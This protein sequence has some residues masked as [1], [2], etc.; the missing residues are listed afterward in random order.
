MPHRIATFDHRGCSLCFGGRHF[1]GFRRAC[2]S[3]RGVDEES[4]RRAKGDNGVGP[5]VEDSAP[6]AR[7]VFARL[8]SPGASPSRG[9]NWR[10]GSG[11]AVLSS[12]GRAGRGTGLDHG[13]G[14]FSPVGTRDH[15]A[16][17]WRY[18]LWLSAF[19]YG[20]KAFGRAIGRG[21]RQR[22]KWDFF[23]GKSSHFV[24][25]CPIHFYLFGACEA[26]LESLS[27]ER[28]RRGR[29]MRHFGFWIG[30]ANAGVRGHS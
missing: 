28:T 3:W 13:E 20:F 18:P 30:G 26:C 27:A 8:G 19:P 14:E 29:G 21:S 1:R 23:L 11:L 22:A 6:R 25:F 16:G 12:L 9:Q 15:G 7:P 5:S 4:L 24:P 10:C 2:L 17:R